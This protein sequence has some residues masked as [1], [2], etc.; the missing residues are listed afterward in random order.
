LLV[1]PNPAWISFILP[2]QLILMAFIVENNIFEASHVTINNNNNNEKLRPERLGVGLVW[3][4]NDS[5]S[6][7]RLARSVLPFLTK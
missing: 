3:G 5:K 2:G 4:R 6:M 1:S 7:A